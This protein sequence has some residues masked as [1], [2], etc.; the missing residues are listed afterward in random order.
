MVGDATKPEDV[1]KVVKGVDVVV[2]CLGNVKKDKENILIMEKSH[3]N[4]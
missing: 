2:S 4:I 3:S 1:A